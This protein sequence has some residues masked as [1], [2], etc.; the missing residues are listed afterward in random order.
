[1]TTRAMTF[2]GT[3]IGKKV[4]MAV[5]GLIVVGWLLAH[6]IGNVTIFAGPEAVNKYAGL[7]RE[8]PPILWGQRL[9][10]LAA[11]LAHIASAFSLWALNNDARP[12]SYHQRKNLAT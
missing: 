2:Y 6:M 4:V 11:I 7:L 3:T 8:N 12:A 5:S 9:V 1:M 10:V